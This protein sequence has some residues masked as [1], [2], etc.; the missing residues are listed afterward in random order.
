MAT[1]RITTETGPVAFVPSAI[2]TVCKEG[3]CV[4]VQDV[5]GE[6]WEALSQG[7]DEIVSALDFDLRR[8]AR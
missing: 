6:W 2:T 8:N 1:I 4:H 5:H 3:D 7:F